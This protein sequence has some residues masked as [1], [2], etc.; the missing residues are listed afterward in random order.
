MNYVLSMFFPSNNYQVGI[1]QRVC[2]FHYQGQG[3]LNSVLM[4]T[5]SHHTLDENETCT[6]PPFNL[7][8]KNIKSY[9]NISNWKFSKTKVAPK[10]D[11]LLLSLIIARN[12]FSL[13][14]TEIEVQPY[15]SKNIV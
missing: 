11:I 14:Q 7:I 10:N 15:H 9:V 5:V 3:Q 12:C 8:F 6:L 2:E 1:S 13:Y 4:S